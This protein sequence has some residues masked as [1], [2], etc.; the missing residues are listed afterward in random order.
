MRS[1][2]RYEPVKAMSVSPPHTTIIVAAEGTPNSVPTPARPLSSLNSAP[3]QATASVDTESHA[4]P[5]P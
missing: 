2:V 4:Q 1:T 5:R 3:T